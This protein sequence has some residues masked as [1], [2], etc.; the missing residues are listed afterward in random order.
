MPLFTRKTKKDEHLIDNNNVSEPHH[1][2]KLSNGVNKS[3]PM[4]EENKPKLIFHCQLAHGSP[5][6]LISGFSNVRELYQK[7]AECYEFPTEEEE[8]LTC[9]IYP[10]L[11][12]SYHMQVPTTAAYVSSHHR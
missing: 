7:I 9:L 11:T 1:K 12:T 8:I 2:S 3:S 10:L 6:G 5:T 4:A